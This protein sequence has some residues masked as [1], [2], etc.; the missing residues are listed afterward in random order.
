MEYVN[1]LSKLT[2]DHNNI[3]RYKHN[4][5]EILGKKGLKVSKNKT[6]NY[7]SRQ[8]H[9]WKKCKLLGTFL[10]TEEDIKRKNIFAI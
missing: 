3:R 4:A 7:I 1:D 2:N 5:E 9:Q 10:D 8:N 6:K